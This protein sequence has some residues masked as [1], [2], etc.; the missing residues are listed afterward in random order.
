MSQSESLKPCPFCGGEPERLELTDEDNFG[1]SVIS[2]KKCGASSPVHFDRKE[3]LDDSWNRRP[4][5][6]DRG[7]E[8]EV[9]STTKPL[10]GQDELRRLLRYDPGTGKLFWLAR[11]PSPVNNAWN[12]K[13]AGHE[14][15]TAT[16]P[17]GYRHGKVNG[18][19]YQAHRIIWKIVHGNDPVAI[20]H[21]NGN[22]SDNS[23]DNLR[24]CTVAENSRNYSKQRAGQSSSYRGVCWVKRDQKWAATISNGQGGKRSLGNYENEEDAARAYDAAAIEMH[25]EFATLNFPTARIRSALAT[26]AGEAI[27]RSYDDEGRAINP[28]AALVTDKG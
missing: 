11:S 22:P 24:E 2:C 8:V 14:A 28:P 3:N 25:G 15:F 20:D 19:V 18:K 12:A 23:L 16:D 26:T 7:G 27:L 5:T 10:P 21:R 13:H 1:G 9:K 17:S 4:S 6:A